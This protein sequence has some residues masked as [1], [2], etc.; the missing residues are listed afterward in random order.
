[1]TTTSSAAPYNAMPNGVNASSWIQ[2][3]VPGSTIRA[4]VS[5]SA[6]TSRAATTS[7]RT[8]TRARTGVKLPLRLQHARTLAWRGVVALPGA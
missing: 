7:Q 8:T 3:A 1:M 5:S 6:G 4:K 2:K